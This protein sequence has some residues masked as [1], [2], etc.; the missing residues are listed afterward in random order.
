MQYTT[1]IILWYT[2]MWHCKSLKN[3]EITGNHRVCKYRTKIW[4]TPE[5]FKILILSKKHNSYI[6]NE[7]HIIIIPNSIKIILLAFTSQEI[8][9]MTHQLLIP[10]QNNSCKIWNIWFSGGE[11][12]LSLTLIVLK[13]IIVGY[14]NSS[15]RESH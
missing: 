5:L 10:L 11:D 7:F 13:D 4:L 9:R 1:F 12:C 2:P 15:L 6:P 14:E 3:W 8:K